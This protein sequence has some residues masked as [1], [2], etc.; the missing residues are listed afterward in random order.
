[1]YFFWWQKV[2]NIYFFQGNFTF[3]FE[4]APLKHCVLY[5][6]GPAVPGQRDLRFGRGRQ[7]AH[8][9]PGLPADAPAAGLA[10]RQLVHADDRLHQPRRLQR[11]GDAKHP[12][13]RSSAVSIP[14]N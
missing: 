5:F 3:F 1:M 7:D 11:R 9:V 6:A 14:Q 4:L 12:Q 2:A 13:V 8:P 10:G